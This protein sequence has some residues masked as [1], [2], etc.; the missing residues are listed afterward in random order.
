MNTDLDPIWEKQSYYELYKNHQGY[1]CHKWTHYP[2]V[3]DQ[4]FSR[5]LDF[6]KPL[7]L[8]EIGVQNGGSLEIWKKYL[9]PNSEIHGLDINPKCLELD[10]SENI[11][12]HLGNAADKVFVNRLFVDKTFDIIIDD[13]SHQSDEV[14]S[15]FTHLFKK[16]NPGGTYIIE[17]L[18][19]SYW[20]SFGGGLHKKNSSVEFFKHFIDALHADHIPEKQFSNNMNFKKFLKSYRQ[21]IASISFFD[22]FC[23]ITKFAQKKHAPFTHVING[24][25]L[26]VAAPGVFEKITLKDKLQD[27]ET[28]RLMYDITGDRPENPSTTEKT[29][30]QLTDGIEA[31][32]NEDFES[33]IEYLS[34]AMAQ[35]Q[36][37]PLPRAYLAFICARQG[38]ATEAHDFITQSVRLAPERADLIAALGEVF[39]KN[40]NPS[41]A[42][43]Y[44]REAVH[45]QPDLFA[46]YP[47][48]AQSLHL[49]GQSE[50]AVSL[51]QTTAALPS[52][53][54]AHIQST[55]LQILAEC[56]DLFEFT[57]TILR[58]SRGL[59]DEL[60]AARCLARFDENG[61][62]TIE[63]LSRIQARLEDVIHS[64]QESARTNPNESGLTRIAFM[65]GNFTSHLQLEQLYAL[66]RYLPTDRFFT[67]LVSCY[68]HPTKD[69]SLQM[70][71]LIADTVLDIRRDK[72]SKVL[73]KLHA[74]APDILV[75]M[76][77][78]APSERL[79]VFL[80]AQAPHKFLWG[81]SP[82]PSIAPNVKTLAGAR[83]SVENTLPTVNLP[84][85]G[86]VF[87]LPELPFID[88]A[89]R[90]MGKPPVLGCLVPA[91]GIGRNGWQLFAETLRQH[92]STTL[93]INL[94]EL[95]QAAQSFISA[96]FSSAGVDPTRLVFI[97]ASTTEE[98]CLAWQS[99]D[100]GLLPPVNPGGLA[101]PTCLWMG[102]PCLIPGSILPWSQR[103]AALLKALGKEEWIAIGSQQYAELALQLAPSGQRVKPD[104]ALRERMK[105]QGLTDPKHFAQGFAD[106]MTGLLRDKQPIPLAASNMCN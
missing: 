22:S 35:E 88:D 61:E 95:R 31:F 17:D 21:E 73:E 45:A 13:G 12:F 49:T 90:N 30:T 51:L 84:E 79:E 63:T 98:Y 52:N 106:A 1:G 11:H 8:L 78:C 65:V 82:T 15:T 6:G 7:C 93:V 67:L 87:D 39:L 96:Q 83:L 10:F 20:E 105:A 102:R 54:Q 57:E 89:A 34:T 23:I 59:P 99:I 74:L 103:P 69:N 60:L 68:T 77:V 71:A 40:S 55:L 26:K 32:K 5:Y 37:N 66:L 2:F 85:M 27:I 25:I 3:Y 50:E 76:E 104:P 36:D 38:L 41:E 33:A 46:A 43:K 94:D 70:C 75:D 100:L 47:A 29:E 16:L 91:A 19:A 4:I 56:G 92:P 72:D 28:A 64:S 14:I 101:L 48:F 9:P 44:L 42:V 97:N 62:K 81:E 80:A 24:D 18:H 58:F 53:S 86:E